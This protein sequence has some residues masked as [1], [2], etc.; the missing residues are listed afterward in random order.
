MNEKLSD[1]DHLARKLYKALQV[2]MAQ[3]PECRSNPVVFAAV[4]GVPKTD[5]GFCKPCLER[6]MEAMRECQRLKVK[7]EALGE[8]F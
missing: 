5:T 4:P 6:A 1:R 8:K 3:C 2:A 7:L